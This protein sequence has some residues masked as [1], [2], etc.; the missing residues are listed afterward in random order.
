[1][2]RTL[3]L[4]PAGGEIPENERL[5]EINA[6][7]TV[8]AASP[9][10]P[11]T[12]VQAPVQRDG[13]TIRFAALIAALALATVSGGFSITGMTAI[14]VGAYWPVIGMGVTVEGGRQTFRGGMARTPAQHG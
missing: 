1:V 14:F 6:S 10:V 8:S 13:R 9:L 3:S 2:L 7:D 12:H 4:H 5:N 11:D